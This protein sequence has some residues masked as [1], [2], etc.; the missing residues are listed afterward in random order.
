MDS[1]KCK[2]C[3]SRK[4]ETEVLIRRRLQNGRLVHENICNNCLSRN[5][6]NPLKKVVFWMRIAIVCLTLLVIYL[7]IHR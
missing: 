4:K 1:I 5:L 7:L 2:Y 6:P 3:G